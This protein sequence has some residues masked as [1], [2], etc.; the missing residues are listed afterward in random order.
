MKSE[1]L[2]Y[3]SKL[4]YNREAF[5]TNY[6]EELAMFEESNALLDNLVLFIQKTRD[7]NGYSH[8]SLLLFIEIIKRQAT[9]TFDCITRFQT[10]TAWINFRPALE[11]LLIIGKFIDNP[12]NTKIWMNKKEYRKEFKKEFTGK[13]LVSQSLPLASKFRELLS[14]I[15]DEFVHSNWNYLNKNYQQ[16]VTNSGYVFKIPYIDK[17]F[18]EHRA[19]LYSF[20]H[21]YRLMIVSIGKAL[22]PK[23]GHKRELHIDH[24]I[25]EKVL[26]PKVLKLVNER[27]DLV[28][29]L[30]IFGIWKLEKLH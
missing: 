24:K 5:L 20:L 7:I 10:F 1:Y 16:I 18:F 11:S 30:K 6:I 22:E 23:F 14:K 26:K 21:I 2:S 28:N 15:N 13:G 9:I 17:D 19:F 4:S 3:S 25:M 29:I 12:Q 8:V 27:S